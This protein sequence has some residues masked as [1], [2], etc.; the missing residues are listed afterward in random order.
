MFA[1]NERPEMSVLYK[2]NR[3][4]ASFQF[5]PPNPNSYDY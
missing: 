1:N 2:L 3:L 5:S 4:I